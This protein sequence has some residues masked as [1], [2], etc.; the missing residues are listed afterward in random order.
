VLQDQLSQK[1][2]RQEKEKIGQIL[3]QLNRSWD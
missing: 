3:L 1:V 2:L